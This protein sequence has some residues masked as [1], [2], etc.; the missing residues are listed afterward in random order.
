[1]FVCMIVS[2]HLTVCA[3]TVT[4][5]CVLCV[6]LVKVSYQFVY[7]YRTKSVVCLITAELF[8]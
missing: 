3:L 7:S 8:S 1:M 4:V 5:A 2:C 6:Y